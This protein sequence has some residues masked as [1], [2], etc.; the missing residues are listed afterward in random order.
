MVR[1]NC[2]IPPMQSEELR[3]MLIVDSRNK[4]LSFEFIGSIH[5]M[6][7]QRAQQIYVEHKDDYSP[8]HRPLKYGKILDVTG[9][10][11]TRELVRMR[12]GYKC[13]KCGKQWKDGERRLDVHHKDCDKEKSRGYDS[14]QS[15]ND[16]ITLCH[17][18]HLNLPQHI[19]AMEKAH[20]KYMK[21]PFFSSYN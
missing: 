17:K 21:Q 14:V 6:T 16:M 11:Y 10:D 19:K 4:G 7:R 9:R 2:D 15:M 8:K 5:N 18:C 20:E 3:D 13:Q 1:L 12:D